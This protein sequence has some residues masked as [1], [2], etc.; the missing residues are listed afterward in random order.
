MRYNFVCFLL[1]LA[2][3][4]VGQ[5][6]FSN[7]S[8]EIK[9][10][11][12]LFMHD[13]PGGN[14]VSFELSAAKALSDS[15]FFVV[16]YDQRG[17]GRSKRD[18]DNSHYTFNQS[19]HD[20]EAILTKYKLSGVDIIAFGWGATEAIK[21]A[22]IYPE[23]IK[24]LILVS[25]PLQY[26]KTFQQILETGK[27]KNRTEKNKK[28]EE[29]I[30][31][32]IKNDTMEIEYY[33]KCLELARVLRLLEPT[34]SNPERDLVYGEMKKSK[35]YN[36]V[37]S[38]SGEP[39]YGF[40]I[41][42]QFQRLDLIYDLKKVIEKGIPVFGVYGAEDGM[43]SSGQLNLMRETFGASRFYKVEGAGHFVYI[44]RLKEF[45]R[46]L[47]KCIQPP[48]AKSKK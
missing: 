14:P 12:V 16:T 22:R 5:A 26:R 45:N 38:L 40:F 28:A 27:A 18:S 21:F 10:R 7:S 13:G 9:N 46:I 48:E 29:I 11:P 6:I 25:A 35:K 3:T 17:C 39:V 24:S 41:Q 36:Y 42:E 33:T 1:G 47:K 43:M 31:Y 44:D 2:I 32:L 4:G 8:G 15:G 23:K 37:D 20:I 34:E 19:N 30:Q